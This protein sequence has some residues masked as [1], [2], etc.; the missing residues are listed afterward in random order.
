MSVHCEHTQCCE[1]HEE[2]PIALNAYIGKTE[3][4]K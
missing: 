4:Y 2:N 1:N 3:E